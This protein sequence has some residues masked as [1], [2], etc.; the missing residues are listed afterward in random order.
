M[1]SSPN[2]SPNVPPTV[3]RRSDSVVVEKPEFH[4]S[5]E[6][7]GMNGVE[8]EFMALFDGDNMYPGVEEVQVVESSQSVPSYSPHS[9]CSTPSSSKGDIDG[10]GG[11]YV[12][13]F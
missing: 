8:D 12:H 6:F 13:N 3:Y 2:N 11:N 9:Q 7:L 4:G 10:K 1:E 5:N